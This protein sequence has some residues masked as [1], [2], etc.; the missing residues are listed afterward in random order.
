MCAATLEGPRTPGRPPTGHGERG[1]VRGPSNAKWGS[2]WKRERDGRMVTAGW[3]RRKH[4][5]EARPERKPADKRLDADAGG[6]AKSAGGEWSSNRDGTR[7]TRGSARRGKAS[8]L[9]ASANAP[10]YLACTG[11][12][13]CCNRTT[14]RGRE[15]ERICICEKSDQSRRSLPPLSRYREL[16]IRAFE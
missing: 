11:Y 2:R 8:S 12:Y 10:F 9:V 3:K 4:D 15:G 1:R 14:A 16:P 5:E 13:C 6:E 7:I